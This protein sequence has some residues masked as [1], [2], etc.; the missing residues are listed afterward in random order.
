MTASTAILIPE[1]KSMTFT[2]AA[3]DLQPSVSMA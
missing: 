1:R 2:P 3:T